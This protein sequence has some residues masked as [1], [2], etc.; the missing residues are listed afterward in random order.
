MQYDPFGQKV[1][2]FEDRV[3]IDA[4]EQGQ[5]IQVVLVVH[6]IGQLLNRCVALS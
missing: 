1:R 4:G 3:V 6:A 5:L 2:Q